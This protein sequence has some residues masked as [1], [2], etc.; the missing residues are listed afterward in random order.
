MV[1]GRY[2]RVRGVLLRL[3]MARRAAAIAGSLLTSIALALRMLDFSWE[4]AFTDG[5]ALV[6]GATGFA[7]LAMAIGGRRPDWKE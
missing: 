6:L 5:L 1:A 4:S 2:H 7:L 3:A